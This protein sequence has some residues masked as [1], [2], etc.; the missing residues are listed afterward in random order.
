M[1]TKLISSEFNIKRHTPIRSFLIKISYVLVLLLLISAHQDVDATPLHL[2]QNTPF[3]FIPPA[4]K[5]IFPPPA[6]LDELDHQSTDS[7]KYPLPFDQNIEH[8]IKIPTPKFFSGARWMIDMGT[9]NIAR[10]DGEVLTLGEFF[11]FDFYTD[12]NTSTRHRDD[13]VHQR[14]CSLSKSVSQLSPLV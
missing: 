3:V 1:R 9:Y 5:P 4:T 14:V 12:L 6:S 11:G 8:K 2:F 10:L 7:K 13:L